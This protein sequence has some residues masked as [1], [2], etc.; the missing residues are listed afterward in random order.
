VA[1]LGGRKHQQ[2][3]QLPLSPAGA[4][5]PA[6]RAPVPPPHRTA[7]FTPHLTPGFAGNDRFTLVRR[8]GGGGMGV[9]YEVHDR[10]R[11]VRVA[12][13]TARSPDPAALYRFKQEFRSLAGVT[14]PNLVPLYELTAVDGG[15]FFTMELVDGAD[16]LRHVRGVASDEPSRRTPAATWSAATAAVTPPIGA[17]GPLRGASPRRGEH[18]V[19]DMA[20]LRDA[21]RQLALGVQALHRSGHLHRDIKPSNILVTPAGRVVLLDFGIISELAG[22]TRPPG[23]AGYGTPDYMAPERVA[24]DPI[25]TEASDWYSVGVVLFEALTG[26]RPFVGPSSVVLEVKQIAEPAPPHVYRADVPED[27]DRLCVDLLRIDPRA[28]PGAAEVLARLGAPAA[29][30][31]A[32]VARAE[33]FVGR[34][35]ELDALRA[36]LAGARRGEGRTVHLHGGAG[37]GKSALARRFLAEVARDP[38]AV[39]LTGRCCECESVPYKALDSLV[40]SLCRHLLGVPPAELGHLLPPEFHLA[41]QLFPVLRR[42]S[43]S[44]DADGAAAN[45]RELRRR[46]F[47]AIRSVL[48]ALARERPLVLFI[49]D[50]QWGDADSV[51]LL[52]ELTHPASRSHLLVLLSYRTEGMST[53]LLQA[54]WRREG[55]LGPSSRATVVE[56]EPLSDEDAVALASHLL[57]GAPD[58]RAQAAAIARDAGG[59]AFFVHELAHHARA[60]GAHGTPGSLQELVTYRIERLVAPARRLL[61]TVAVAGMPI[62]HAVA[63]DAAGLTPAEAQAALHTLRAA[64]LVR[65]SGVGEHDLIETYHD[66]IRETLVAHLARPLRCRRHLALAESLLAHNPGEADAIAAHFRDGEDP[67]RAAHHAEIA[68]DHALQAFAFDR[69]TTLYRNALESSAAR[70]PFPPRLRE[71]L[72]QALSSAGRAAEAAACY[73]DAAASAGTHLRAVELTLEA[74]YELLHAGHIDTGLEVLE[75][76]VDDAGLRLAA[77]P[78]RALV[79]LVHRRTRLRLRLRRPPRVSPERH[80][81]G[82][83]LARIDAG[84]HV[85]VTLGM[86]D[87]LRGIELATRSALTA[88]AAGEPYRVARAIATDAVMVAAAAMPAGEERAW[89]MV[90]DAEAVAASVARTDLDGLIHIATAMLHYQ[91]CRF[92]LARAH[93]EKA[94]RIL[95]GSRAAGTGFWYRASVEH[96]RLW[97]LHYLG[98]VRALATAT[99]ERVRDAEERGDR[100]TIAGLRTG[101]PSL[102]W[103]AA[104]E[105]TECRRGAVEAVERW[106]SRGYHLQHYWQLFALVQCDLYEGAGP[107]AYRRILAGW[108]ALRR[109][110]LLRMP[111]VRIE[112]EHLRARAAL[113]AAATGNRAAAARAASVARWLRRRPLAIAAPLADLVA[114]ALADLRADRKRAALRCDA[115]AAGFDRLDMSLFAAAAR[116][117]AADLSPDVVRRARARTALDWMRSQS[118]ASPERMTEL[119]APGFAQP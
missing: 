105:P 86:V 108:P 54:L 38:G 20:R 6:D 34:Q 93:G 45:A 19:T 29:S 35:R 30:T 66:R 62:S 57:R 71:K 52:C 2:P 114:A 112:A 7:V 107:D 46:A 116:I 40:D 106:S 28:R 119:L 16:F 14:H 113:A 12:L 21:L 77:S 3:R 11:D 51:A 15:W 100:Y 55:R 88:L 37:V 96:Y 117:R 69:A 91:M 25:G 72:G 50:L 109:S 63:R 104:G 99:R 47:R 23:D 82:E 4:R 60:E 98:D 81:A 89:R 79:G 58:G 53:P 9:V 43:G 22:A 1:G 102:T 70:G 115:A 8:L 76:V 31:G 32:P 84:Y 49:D 26:Q 92:Q 13:K 39:I 97:S 18:G 24:I 41:G 5:S 111:L 33:L 65:S 64:Y 110:L 68:G 95:R 73:L 10:L 27:L 59:N 36:A 48:L 42:L 80:L 17:P 61:E 118:I 103:L 83:E 44:G 90:R 101:L 87:W 56:I 78:R 75:R 74:V 94:I 85:G 67:E